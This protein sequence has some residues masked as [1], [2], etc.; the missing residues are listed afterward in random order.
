M[1][2]R[3]AARLCLLALL[4]AFAGEASAQTP[5][6]PPVTPP[7][8]RTRIV[9]RLFCGKP[10]CPEQVYVTPW[11]TNALGDIYAGDS[12]ILYPFNREMAVQ[13]F[14]VALREWAVPG[15]NVVGVIGSAF[16]GDI[17]TVWYE[18]RSGYVRVNFKM[19][20]RFHPFSRECEILSWE[21]WGRTAGFSLARAFVSGTC[22]VGPPVQ[23]VSRARLRAG[24]PRKLI[25][26]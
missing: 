20:L 2:W 7:D 15:T 18:M 19:R 23:A 12:G 4:L 1:A 10:D 16:R 24:A 9:V 14:P 17:L 21:H 5:H 8:F 3:S 6:N 26:K 25:T 22:T 13:Q 11:R